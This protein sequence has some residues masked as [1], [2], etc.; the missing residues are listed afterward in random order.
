[1]D[2][3]H[4]IAEE[5][6]KKAERDGDFDDLPGKGKPLP[7][8]PHANLSPGM[9]AAAAVMGNSGFVTEE[10]DL[11]RAMNEAREALGEPGTEAEKAERMAT[12]RDAE[13]RYNLAMERH[14]RIFREF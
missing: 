10:V 4:K 5:R 11:L 3:L 8:D 2:W 6:M 7:P 1:M 14:K 13:L 9:R 12:F